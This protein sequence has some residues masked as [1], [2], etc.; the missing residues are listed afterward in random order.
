MK[1]LLSCIFIALLLFSLVSCHRGKHF[2]ADSAL[3]DKVEQQFKKQEKLAKNR[4][5]ELFKVFNRKD[6]NRTEKEALEF[7]YA[8]MS[9]SD[10]A[11][12]NGEFFLKNVR[13]SL[14]ARD[15]FSWC[16][17][18][19]DDIF[20]HF[21]LPVR[22][23]NEDLDSSRWV[24]FADLKDRVR[25][26]SMKDAVLEVNHWCHEK[27]TYKAS[28]DRTSAPLATVKNAYGRCGEESTFAVAA[29]RAVGIP[30]RQ[31]YTPRWAH[32]DDN[33]AWVE[34]WVD[35]KWHYLGACEPEP[36]LDRAWFTASAKRAMLVNTNVFG[37]YQGPEDVLLRDP[38]FTRINVLPTYTR[39]KRVFIKVTDHAQKPADSA[40]VEFQLYNYAEFY[41]LTK[42]FTDKKGL[43][44]FLTGYGDLL[45]WAAKD[46]RFGYRELTVKECDTITISLSFI[47]G[48]I[49]TEEMDFVP[50][51]PKNDEADISDALKKKNA[52]QFAAEDRIRLNY[53]QT[54]IDSVKTWRLS[55]NLKMNP[56]TLWDF[57]K[58]SR[59]NWRDIIDFITSVPDEKKHLVFPLL[60][61]ISEKDLRDIT[62]EVLT[63]Q[64]G[65][66]FVYAPMTTDRS[67][68]NSCILSPRI[69]V[70]NLRPY[71]SYF[72]QRFDKSFVQ[73]A[74]KDPA[75]II[76][77][78][79]SY[80]VPGNNAN[81][82]RSPLSPIG[83][84]ELK[85]AD[86]ISRNILFV[87][88][89][90]SFGI[91]A[92]LEPATRIPQYLSNETWTDVYFE[93]QAQN[94]AAKC[95][96]VL[97]NDPGN[98]RKPQYFTDFTIEKL[99]NGFY[100]SLDYETELS[101][102]KFPYTVELAP[103]SYLVVTGSR[104]A[105]G[106][107]LSRLSFFNLGP[108]GTKSI[109]L[110]LR[111]TR[112]AQSVLGVV[113][114]KKKFVSLLCGISGISTDKGFVVAWLDPEKEPSR[115]FIA[116]LLLKKDQFGRD[117]GTVFLLFRNENDKN[118]FLT[119]NS[120]ALPANAR[121]MIA[122]NG[123]LKALANVIHREIPENFPV[124]T[125]IN[126]KGEIS[127]LSEGYK[128]GSCEEIIHLIK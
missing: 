31:C 85:V 82:S 124:V 125:Y 47:A 2:L 44:S 23:N 14:A 26:L 76:G 121:C 98:N 120:N 27:V 34:V 71:K 55:K 94:E 6:I 59:G 111:N 46:N 103:G 102:G 39:T 88:L 104:L 58:R 95:K 127:Y 62:P 90:R 37:E 122:A 86:R 3:R 4:S 16:A 41:P 80:I 72:Q 75:T 11:D 45:V 20:R 43:C 100:R 29:L 81:Y 87:A 7:L 119:K 8:Y 53:E 83:T 70:E 112:Q 116:D 33:H 74:R 92:R 60:G 106:T 50:P 108:G 109:P 52:D 15:T 64:V 110:E 114:D 13:S 49:A 32:C 40:I 115:H 22:V 77:W 24:F 1:K 28:D 9:L 38:L 96:L 123:S 97:T 18:I 54:F 30:A 69:D 79:R 105:D 25:K 68:L 19:P 93:K 10:L 91:P 107:V 57:L 17:N 99:E 66:S 63:D 56:D 101:T 65:N 78:I 128:I 61:S 5:T 67:I 73:D 51:P 118:I 126:A 36:V 113:K 48:L 35:G 42:T 117:F 12:Y 84:Y 21:V 89:C